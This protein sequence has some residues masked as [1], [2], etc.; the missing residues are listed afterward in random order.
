MYDP[1]LYRDENLNHRGYF[2]ASVTLRR[3]NYRG[4]FRIPGHIGTSGRS[5]ETFLAGVF[6]LDRVIASRHHYVGITIRSAGWSQM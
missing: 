2:K 5:E 3:G 1:Y 4:S 6:V